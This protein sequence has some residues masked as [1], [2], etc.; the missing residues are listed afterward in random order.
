[1]KGVK[2]KSSKTTVFVKKPFGERLKLDFKRHWQ[3]YLL[4]LPVIVYFLIFNYAPMVGIGMAFD[5]IVSFGAYWYMV[6]K[7]LG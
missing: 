2:M 4:A 6:R 1:M 7:E 3:M 5:S